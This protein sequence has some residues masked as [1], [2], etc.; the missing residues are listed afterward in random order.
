MRRACRLA[1]TVMEKRVVISVETTCT[2][3]VI[4]QPRAKFYAVDAISGKQRWACR[5]NKGSWVT[6]PV[7]DV[8]K[9]TLPSRMAG[10]LRMRF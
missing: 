3:V 4:S 9:Y 1:A 8:A 2:S 5:Q 10:E 6:S 7:S